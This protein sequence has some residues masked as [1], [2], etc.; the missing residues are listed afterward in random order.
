M[1]GDGK[2]KRCP[3]CGEV[4]P[5]EAF[6]RG[7]RCRDGLQVYCR[8][9]EKAYRVA[10]RETLLAQKKE[11]YAANK[12]TLGAKHKAYYV[13]NK[14]AI[15]AR[16]KGYNAANKGTLA[17]K[18]QAKAKTR[19]EVNIVYLASLRPLRCET[20]GYDKSFAALDFHHT[21]P[22]Q[23][24]HHRDGMGKW[25]TLPLARFQAKVQSVLF[26]ILCANCHRELH[27]NET[28]RT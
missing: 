10:N 28:R 14:E 11:Y 21:D 8:R 4:K 27:E 6:C 16:T 13:A 20:C 2:S 25:L 5:L 18:R 23:K 7:R 22:S 1:E 24:K 26:M 17:P 15:L 9:C 3:K 12:E 19:R